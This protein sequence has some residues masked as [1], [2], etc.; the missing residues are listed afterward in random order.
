MTKC[1]FFNDSIEK[2]L[3][4][5]NEY[6]SKRYRRA[7]AMVRQIFFLFMDIRTFLGR[8][9][10]EWTA[11]KDLLLSVKRTLAK[12]DQRIKN[13]SIGKS[14]TK[15]QKAIRLML[16]LFQ[17]IPCINARN[18]ETLKE[19]SASDLPAI[20]ERFKHLRLTSYQT[21]YVKAMLGLL[22]HLLLLSPDDNPDSFYKKEKLCDFSIQMLDDSPFSD[23]DTF[24][25]LLFIRAKLHHHRIQ[26]EFEAC[27]NSLVKSK[28]YLSEQ[29][30]QYYEIDK[31]L[32]NM[33]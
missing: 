26:R 3:L 27:K 31:L 23:N 25:T 29:M 10:N 15:G 30:V 14:V 4:A 22:A 9:E 11:Y 24:G 33:K 19:S 32:D 21:Y 28:K 8:T 16:S 18:W 7:D 5:T 13:L 2:L 12:T 6:C 20:W 1:T 17:Y